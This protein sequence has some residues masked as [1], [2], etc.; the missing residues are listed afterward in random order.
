MNLGLQ[1]AFRILVVL[2]VVLLVVG[3]L[4]PQWVWRW[5]K[6]EPDRL[7]I[8]MVALLLFMGGF[9]GLGEISQDIGDDLERRLG[10][11]ILSKAEYRI[12]PGTKRCEAGARPGQAGAT[13]DEETSD[14]IRYNVRTP[15]NY[16]STIAHPLLMVYSPYGK[17][18]N[19]TEEFTYLTRDAHGSRVHCGLC[20]SQAYGPGNPH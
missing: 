2:S 13:D 17:N 7:V 11:Q 8:T 4:K 14:G 1:F 15:G 9:T 10:A 12:G 20:G 19:R 16:D 5:K 3:L 6:K 18:R